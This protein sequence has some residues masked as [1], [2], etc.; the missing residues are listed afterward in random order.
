MTPH[1]IGQTG[2]YRFDRIFP[3]VGRINGS[4]GTTKAKEFQRR[5]QLLTELFE[6][7]QLEALRAFQRGDVTIEELLEAKRTGRL[8]S[9]AL[10]PM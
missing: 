3:G 6:H 10:P 5:D 9:A 1:R 2:S 8:T 7:A 4:S